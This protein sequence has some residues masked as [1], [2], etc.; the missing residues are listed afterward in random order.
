MADVLLS[1]LMS[2]MVRNLNAS[3][4][5]EFGVAWGLSSELEK[6]ESTLSTIQAVIQDADGGVRLSGIGCES[7]KMELMMRMMF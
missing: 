4:L 7:S 6:L 1:A 3:A 5:Q 2:S